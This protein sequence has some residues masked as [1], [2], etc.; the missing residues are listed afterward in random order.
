MI[1]FY[2]RALGTIRC[3]TPFTHGKAF[4][5]TAPDGGFATRTVLS[6]TTLRGVR[7]RFELNPGL[8]RHHGIQM[9]LETQ[10]QRIGTL[11]D[12]TEVIQINTEFVS[13]IHVKNVHPKR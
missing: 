13:R 11:G 9:T 8:R 10:D 6:G 2:P 1:G 5:S 3:D 7:V 4:E 12:Q